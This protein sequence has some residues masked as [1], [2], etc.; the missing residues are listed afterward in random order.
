MADQDGVAPATMAEAFDQGAEEVE[1]APSPAVVPTPEAPAEVPKPD[2]SEPE[3][4]GQPRTPDGKFAAKPAA[5]APAD[6]QPDAEAAPAEPEPAAV[7]L[8]QYPPLTFRAAGR[9]LPFEG[10][11]ASENGAWFPKE[12]LPQLTRQLAAAVHA[13]ELGNRYHTEK[14][15]LIA[16]HTEA[17]EG[18]KAELGAKD[19][20]IA[21]FDVLR[22][23]AKVDPQG[24]IDFL[25][26]DRGWEL[27]QSKA[28]QKIQDAKLAQLSKKEEARQAEATKQQQMPLMQRDFSTALDGLLGEAKAQGVTLDRAEMEQRLLGMWDRMFRPATDAEVSQGFRPGE[29]LFDKGPMLEEIRWAMRWAQK[30]VPP[31]PKP[32]VK[33]NPVPPAARNKAPTA[34]TVGEKKEAPSFNSA[35]EAFESAFN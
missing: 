22:K 13:S 4:Q 32:V 24:V 6:V 19:A 27:W 35:R 20:L 3:A 16:Q 31:A 26:D 8:S 28:Q 23:E 14:Q 18:I 29:M 33:T 1:A 7:D 12:V 5:E 10:S 11:V 34:G 15:Q 25:L 17:V 2:A 21:Q 30:A 9:E